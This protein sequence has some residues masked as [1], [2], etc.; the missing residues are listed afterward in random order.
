MNVKRFLKKQA[1]RDRQAILNDDNG[2]TLRALGVDYPPSKPK[3]R[4]GAMIFGAFG[5]AIAVVLV[6]CLIVLYP[7]SQKI[8]YIE[9]NLDSRESDLAELNSEIHD[10][11]IEIDSSLYPSPQVTRT[12]DRVSGDGLYYTVVLNSYDS[13]TSL[14][15]VVVCNADF[16]YTA[17]E[18]EAT[19]ESRELSSYAIKY[20]FYMKQDEQFGLTALTATAEINGQ[21]DVVYI[22]KYSEL[23]FEAEPAFFDSIQQIVRPATHN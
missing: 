10:F 3:K 12:F 6:I 20:L 9:A 14:M 1:R 4:L 22:T 17:F 7:S 13:F 5:T 21:Q 8:K 23:L 2:K 18:F 19:P 15:F 16:E 11:T